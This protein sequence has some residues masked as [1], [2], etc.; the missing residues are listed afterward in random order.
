MDHVLTVSKCPPHDGLIGMKFQ[1]GKT[2][3]LTDII[4]S[5]VVHSGSGT[6]NVSACAGRA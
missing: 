4:L 5:F 3:N 6:G 1:L 2:Y